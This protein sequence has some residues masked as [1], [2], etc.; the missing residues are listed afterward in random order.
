VDKL[1]LAA[2]VLKILSQEYGDLKPM[3]RYGDCFQLLISVILSA[4]TTDEQVNRAT[5]E[6]F[7]RYPGAE[8]LSEADYEAVEELIHGVG[9][10]HVKARHIIETARII[11]DQYQGN[12]PAE[13]DELTRLPGVGRK[14]AN[15]VKGFCF[16]EPA[17]IVDTHFMRVCRRIGLAE[18]KDP[19]YMEQEIRGFLPREDYTR[20]SMIINRHGRVCCNARKPRCYTCAVETLCCYA[21][22]VL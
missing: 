4:Q 15:V 13:M 12:V 22:K 9:F 18:S 17:I 16:G 19:G 20:F 2:S 21:G 1:E 5:G 7:R 10:F 14:S 3:L 6:L 11:H 8:A